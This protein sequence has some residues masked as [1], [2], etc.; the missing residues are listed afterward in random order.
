MEESFHVCILFPP[1]AVEFLKCV[2]VCVCV[3]VSTGFSTSKNQMQWR[4]KDRFW[5][6]SMLLILNGYNEGNM[7]TLK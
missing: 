1:L 6:F 4:H 3:L 2:C 5:S 7:G